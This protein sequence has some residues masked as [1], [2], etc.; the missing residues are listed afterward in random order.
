MV[1]LLH[2][3]LHAQE[4]DYSMWEKSVKRKSSTLL[5]LKLSN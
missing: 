4:S 1:I 5:H 3:F 2:D